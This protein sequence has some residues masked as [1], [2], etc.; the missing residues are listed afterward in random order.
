MQVVLSSVSPTA[1]GQG[2]AERQGSGSPTLPV[3]R[4]LPASGSGNGAAIGSSGNA[5]AARVT[6]GSLSIGCG[7]ITVKAQADARL[8]R[9][10]LDHG[11][12]R[13]LLQ[14]P[15][16]RLHERL[17]VMMDSIAHRDPV[18]ICRQLTPVTIDLYLA[19]ESYMCSNSGGRSR[20][21]LIVL[22]NRQEVQWP[23]RG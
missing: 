19:I 3:P 11:P 4:P 22:T 6:L 21:R 8:R 17:L 7:Q 1:V 14:V 2:A 12:Q 15:Q 13:Q 10:R 23:R 9:L 20:P 5:T 16:L 18:A